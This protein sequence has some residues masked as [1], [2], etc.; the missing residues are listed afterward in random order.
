MN[1]KPYIVGNDYENSYYFMFSLF[2]YDEIP[3]VFVAMSDEGKVCLCNCIEFFDSQKWVIT[4]TTYSILEALTKQKISVLEALK[5]NTDKKTVVEYNYMTKAFSQRKLNFSEID[6]QLL[7]L[8]N[9]MLRY[10]EEDA[11]KKL[12]MIYPLFV[13]RSVLESFIAIDA[14]S[15]VQ[16][17]TETVNF[18]IAST[19]HYTSY[20]STNMKD[21]IAVKANA[22]FDDYQE[23]QYVA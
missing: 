21:R 3:I 18:N 6:E 8:N 12:S 22:P 23:L 14:I 7:P 20:N 13:D 16:Q 2:E 11:N 17:K 4:E 10:C 19:V 15:S 1:N 9:V 5:S